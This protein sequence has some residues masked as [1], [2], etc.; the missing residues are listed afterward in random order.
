MDLASNV[1]SGIKIFL[2]IN[3]LILVPLLGKC[4]WSIARDPLTPDVSKAL[5]QRFTAKVLVGIV[6]DGFVSACVCMYVRVLMC[7]EPA[8][9]RVCVRMCG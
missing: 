8:N 9:V 2:L 1:S 7:G 4:L 3:C 5:W 6:S